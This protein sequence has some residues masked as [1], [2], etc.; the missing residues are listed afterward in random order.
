M[1]VFIG[2]ICKLYALIL[3]S[4]PYVSIHTSKRILSTQVAV[5]RNVIMSVVKKILSSLGSV[6]HLSFLWKRKVLQKMPQCMTWT[7]LLGHSFPVLPKAGHFGSQSPVSESARA[8]PP[9]E[10]RRPLQLWGQQGRRLWGH[11]A[12]R[13]MKGNYWGGQRAAT[14]RRALLPT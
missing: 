7:C 5:S 1:W 11:V 13:R 10:G 14:T 3:Q 12:P 2:A 4:I 8:P 6:A 9:A